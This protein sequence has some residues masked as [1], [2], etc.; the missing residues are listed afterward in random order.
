MT[1]TSPISR[2]QPT[3]AQSA[4]DELL[5]SIGVEP[6]N[7]PTRFL[8][9]LGVGITVAVVGIVLFV[10]VLFGYVTAAELRAKGYDVDGSVPVGE[11]G[12]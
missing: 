12:P 8:A 9:W 1:Q 4:S 3:A 10:Y 11:A 7:P 2:A 5:A 6:D